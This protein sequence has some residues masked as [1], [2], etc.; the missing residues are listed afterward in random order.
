M[1]EEVRNKDFQR[2]N[3]RKRGGSGK[4]SLLCVHRHQG[5]AVHRLMVAVKFKFKLPKCGGGASSY[6]L[7]ESRGRH[8]LSIQLDMVMYVLLLLPDDHD[9]TVCYILSKCRNAS[10][11]SPNMS[12]TV[13]AVQVDTFLINYNNTY[14]LSIYHSVRHIILYLLGNRT[15]RM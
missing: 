15:Y 14:F 13:R 6:P 11:S 12:G 4:G 9:I 5:Q 3:R 1:S 2:F 10:E 8:F 7:F